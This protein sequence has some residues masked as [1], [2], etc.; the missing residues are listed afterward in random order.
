MVDLK[1]QGFEEPENKVGTKV[2][3]FFDEINPFDEAA[4][5]TTAG[6]ITE[7]L[8]NI[9]IP[10]GI[11]FTKGAQLANAAIKGKKAKKYFQL[12]QEGA[13]AKLPAADLRN[14]RL[15]ATKFNKKEKIAKYGLASIGAGA[16][17]GVF[18]ADVNKVG[19]F[20]DLLG[21]P[22]E[23]D[24]TED[25]D[26]GREVLNRIKFGT[27]GALF[28]GVIGGT[29]AA[30]GKLINRN[31]NLTRSDD[32]MDSFLDKFAGKLRARSQKDPEFFKVER[33]IEGLKSEDIALAK[34]T[35]REITKEIDKLFPYIKT[36]LNSSAKN[37]RTK[38]LNELNDVLLSLKEGNTPTFSANKAVAFGSMNKAKS[39]ELYKKLKSLGA[40]TDSIKNIFGQMKS[41]RSKWEEM[42]SYIGT[43][44][45]PDEFIDFKSVFG[46]KFKNFL[47][48]N[49]D[50]FAN[51]SLIPW[52]NYK[53]TK[54]VVEKL[55]R[56]IIKYSGGKIATMETAEKYVNEI[57]KS[58]SLPN[59]KSLAMGE[60]KS[61]SAIFKLPK[62]LVNNSVLNDV[63]SFG[64]FKSGTISV[65]DLTP[66]FKKSI[67][68]LF[69]KQKNVGI[70]ILG[71]TER[72]SLIT[73]NNQ[74]FQM[75]SL[76][77]DE[78]V[79]KAMK[80]IAEGG[81]NLTENSARRKY[82]MF[83]DE[84]EYDEA[85]KVF[86]DDLELIRFDAPELVGATN[87]LNKKYT[88]KGMANAVMGTTN[89]LISNDSALGYTL[90]NFILF[91]KATSQIAKTILSPLTHVRNFISAG[92]F[93]VANGI[94]PNT[95]AFAEAYKA[96]QI[97]LKGAG[98]MNGFYNKLLKLG[99]VNSEAGQ[100][101]P[102][103][104]LLREMSFLG[105][106]LVNPNTFLQKLRQGATKVRKVGED[107]Y[108]AEDDFWKITTFIGER[109]RLDKSYKKFGLKRSADQLDE[110][111]AD[112]VRN[113]IP[114]YAYVS[115][116]VKGLRKFPLG[117]FVSFPAEIMRTGTN[118]V[119]RGLYEINYKQTL[120][121]GE[122]VSPLKNI[123]I[124]RLVGFGATV[125]AVPT[126]AVEGAK[127][128]YNVTEEEMEALRRYVPSWSKNSTLVPI[129]DKKT[130]ELKYIDFS[131]TNAYDTLIR[132]IQTV[133]NAVQEGRTDEDGIMNDFIS[134]MFESTKEI[135]SPFISES[136]WTEAATDILI[137]GGRTREGSVLYTDQTP[138][139]EKVS[140]ILNHL[141][142]TQSP[143]SLAQFKRIGLGISG[144]TDDYGRSY[145]L[146]DELQGLVGF[147]AIKVEPAR[148]INF[149]I[150]DFQRGIRNSRREFTS[151]LLKGGKV[152]PS[153]IV[154]R[155]KVANTQAYKVKQEMMKDYFAALRLGAN[156]T[157]V[158]K[159]FDE[160]GL[161]K[162]L[163]FLTNGIFKPL[164]ISDNVQRSFYQ[165][166]LK[167]G[168]AN[169]YPVA[170]NVI[171]SM[172]GF[173]SSVPLGLPELPDFPNPFKNIELP[174]DDTSFFQQISSDPSTITQVAGSTIP[175]ENQ[176]K[177]GT[178]NSATI[179]SFDQIVRK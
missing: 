98:Q 87:P 8:V 122:V 115:D 167:A 19:T 130:G 72:L 104:D 37:D 71:G 15:L 33:R 165:N 36:S 39:Q 99:V 38:L 74:Y 57:I 47:G 103:K 55:S 22:T 2:E 123:G 176:N 5:A 128:L 69:G 110:E 17:E 94:I 59:K 112:I 160:R 93:S 173:Y 12:R 147:R 63:K 42:F 18:V 73:R 89:S 14:A 162:E 163:G 40:D 53:P 145:E 13:L 62:E 50:I 88:S 148:A 113:N 135:A 10:G 96:L 70:T 95:K 1:V 91:P 124:K 65:D 174:A 179:N 159:S 49:Y 125:A 7:T 81:E 4:E 52:L 67:E 178:T 161:K 28:S 92:A 140:A 129:R 20:G 106:G 82:K 117:N 66:N 80:P 171:N 9:G 136:I 151:K 6:K 164:K 43:R 97:P 54:Q 105:E 177:L 101:G 139:G 132:P 118:I 86:G 21:G 30:I 144:E 166:A 121:N 134:G 100:I 26:P 32:A 138:P 61:P 64:K 133:L 137:R 76:Q 143:G 51:K 83:F 3:A 48:S 75:L 84:E 79:K 120:T 131:R 109:A 107:F 77:S 108:T 127:A 78:L 154:D 172:L 150:A 157:S 126:A 68:E 27:E 31:K 44:M 141:V 34:Q 16:A 175:I 111:A 85:L 41:I 156:P 58:A 169:P 29:G 102:T 11:A 56:E 146:G 153:D 152:S 155:Y 168:Q 23:L 45:E 114:N 170:A 60:K 25:Y 35:Q 116:F 90:N 46:N 24:R 119:Q 149:K 158:I 142:K